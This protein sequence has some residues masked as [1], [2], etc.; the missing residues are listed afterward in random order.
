[1][2]GIDDLINIPYTP[3]LTEGGITYACHS[4]PH[5]YN[6][7]GRSS[8]DRLRHMAAGAAVELALRRYLTQ[9]NISFGIQGAVPFTQPNRYDVSLG[10]HR[11][12]LKSFLISHRE[13]IRALHKDIGLLLKAPALVPLDQYS[14]DGRSENDLY[15]FAFMTGLVSRSLNDLNKS[16]FSALPIYLIHIMSAAWSRPQAW[17]PL[18]PLTLKSETGEILDLEIGGQNAV[19]EFITC[20][21]ELPPPH[22][23]YCGC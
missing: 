17:I 18:G 2:L 11:C 21:L 22:S 9:Q 7:G 19:R 6:Y 1:M 23:L 10:G 12:D 16:A 15:L 13:Q 14:A 5:I 3:D 8:F 4:L 20:S